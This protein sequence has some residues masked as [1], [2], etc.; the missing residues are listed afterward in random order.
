MLNFEGLIVSA[1][2]AGS[3]AFSTP[4]GFLDTPGPC[5]CRMDKF[6]L[7]M[8]VLGWGPREL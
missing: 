5:T 4:I 2:V 1:G 7:W 8:L 6:G 3:R